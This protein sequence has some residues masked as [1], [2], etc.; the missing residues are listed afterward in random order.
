MDPELKN[1]HPNPDES[2]WK[3]EK[4]EILHKN[5]WYSYVHDSGKTD[6]KKDFEY[7]YSDIGHT[8][9]VIAL[10]KQGKLILVKQYRYT[11][12]ADSLEVPGGGKQKNLSP[13]ELAKQELKEETGYEGSHIVK[14]GEFNAFSG[15]SNNKTSV[16]LVSGCK[17]TSDQEL[18]E[19]EEGME[20]ELYDPE[21]VFEMVQDG[22]INDGVTLAALMVAWPHLL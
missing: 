11:V 10:T 21:V 22:K 9:S 17:K 3:V 8:S 15:S 16:F 19:T 7:F 1:I 12:N 6:T 5:R 4:R 13:E 20:V 18:E 2:K 14:I